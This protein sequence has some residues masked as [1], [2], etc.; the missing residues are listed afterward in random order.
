MIRLDLKQKLISDCCNIYML[1]SRYND[2]LSPRFKYLARKSINKDFKKG[3]KA[4]NK[5]AAVYIELPTLQP[6]G[7]G[8]YSERYENKPEATKEIIVAQNPAELTEYD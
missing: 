2:C 4:I 5:K 8:M 7:N 6:E 1:I 3:L